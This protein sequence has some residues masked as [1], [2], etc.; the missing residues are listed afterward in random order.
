M[1]AVSVAEPSV[2]NQLMSPGTFRKRKYLIAA[3][4]AGAL[5]DPVQRIEDPLL[6]LLLSLRARR[7]QL[8]RLDRV[9][10]GLDA[11]RRARRGTRSFVLVDLRVRAR[12]LR[13]C[14]TENGVP[15]NRWPLTIE[16]E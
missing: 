1:N 15:R 16:N 14:A 9:Q 7:H 4:E 13:P 12:A 5:L 8:R 2:W 6:Q 3:D 11:R 10:P